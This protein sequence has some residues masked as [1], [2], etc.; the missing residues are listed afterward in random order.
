MP[1]AK[2][3]AFLGTGSDVGKSIVVTAVCRVLRNRGFS[4]APYKAQ[5][6]SNNSYVTREGGEM[7]RAQI[8]QAEAAGCE[9][10]VDMN[11]VL[12]KPNTDVGA[13]IVVQGKVKGNA[14]ASEYFRNT[15]AL[16]GKAKESLQ[17]LREKAEVIVIEGAGSCGEVNLRSRDFVNFETAHA[18]DAPVI[19]V[20]DI[21]KGG[22]F[23]QIV[24][25]LEVIPPRD[26]E[27]VAGFVINK[28]RGDARL[29]D[30]GIQFL[31]ERTGLPVLGLIPYFR[32]I[33]IDSED[34]MP[35]D[36]VIDPPDRPQPD[37]INLAAIR[38]PHISNFT[39]FNPLQR[40]DAV[41]FHYLSKPRDL[42]RYDAIFLPGSKNVRFDLNWLREVGW[43]KS[44]QDAAAAGCRVI[45]VCGGYQML[46]RVIR[47]PHGVEGEP[48][49]TPGFG[50]LDCETEL[51]ADKVLCRST[52]KVLADGTPIDGYEIHM[53]RTTLG[54]AAQ[55]MV[56]IQVRNAEP[57]AESDGARNADGTVWGSYF[58]GLFD[59]PD[60]RSQFLRQLDPAF[61]GTDARA[62][63][64]FKDQQ[65]DLL[66]EHFSQHLDI[67]RLL[68]IIG[69]E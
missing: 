7:G 13:Q 43:E 11:P 18:C 66:A 36:T 56:Q 46:G 4:V 5:N 22:I 20:G 54:P 40:E 67:P 9:P 37:R 3:I 39:D 19:L 42:T 51:A 15:D 1:P 24:G 50:L 29:F 35:L 52:G 58:H 34:G 59:H 47:D 14:L 6:M 53:G 30:D 38:L 62:A 33:E 44:L 16:F 65:Y 28:F 49:D 32:H 27:R 61:H 25:T 41:R 31:E 12:L 10:H 8:A 60:L 63:A 2:C 45:G 57:V 23:A 48:G 64:Q 55:P 17:R 21:D 68:R 26:R 69:L